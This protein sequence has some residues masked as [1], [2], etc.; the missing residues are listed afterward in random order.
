M[1]GARPLPAIGVGSLVGRPESHVTAALGQDT[2]LKQALRDPADRRLDPPARPLVPERASHR[3]H[4]IVPSHREVPR[5]HKPR[6]RRD[7][8]GRHLVD[9]PVGACV[10]RSCAGRW[11]PARGRHVRRYLGLLKAG[12]RRTASTLEHKRDPRKVERATAA[13]AG[14][15]KKPR[16]AG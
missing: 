2:V 6:R 10:S 8:V 12:Y 3:H 13:L 1:S 15:K 11:R 14:L 5:Q 7:L 4:K 9:R 16:P